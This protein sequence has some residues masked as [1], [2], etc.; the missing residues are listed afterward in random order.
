MKTVYH[1]RLYTV[2]TEHD[3]AYHAPQGAA[4][5]SLRMNARVLRAGAIKK[6]NWRPLEFISDRQVSGVQLYLTFTTGSLD[7][8]L[9]RDS[10]F[11]T[12]LCEPATHFFMDKSVHEE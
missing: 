10:E 12:L 2:N 11:T 6:G 1:T 3:P 5:V 9:T 4:L 8:S 7:V